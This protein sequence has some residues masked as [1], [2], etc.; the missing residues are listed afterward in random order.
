M[1]T[2]ARI[3]VI[4]D[5][6]IVCESCR[7]VLEQEGYEVSTT[8]EG[9]EGLERAWTEDFDAVIVDIRMPRTSGFEV[10]HG[11]REHKP[12]TAVVMITGYPSV[13]AAVE[14]LRGGATDYLVKPFTPDELCLKVGKAIRAGGDV[15]ARGSRIGE[16]HTTVA[17]RQVATPSAEIL[18]VGA[19]EHADALQEI[20][21]SEQCC[22]EMT[23]HAE[24]VLEKV[25]TGEV[26]VLILGLE[27]F[28][29]HG[30]DL[31]PAVREIKDDIPIIVVSSAQSEELAQNVRRL[32]ILFYLVEPFGAEEV[33][34]VIR[35][36][37]KKVPV[38]KK[39]I[40][41]I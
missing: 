24:E 9:R 34:A 3:L 6:R 32:G 21:R 26:E 16:Q 40:P 25:R 4:D 2:S 23:Y 15:V 7:R 38:F 19:W 31:V 11:I 13:G 29:L 1:K 30:D 12:E 37:A 8:T 27:A 18:I 41:G 5:Q 39:A 28:R 10:L 36:A 33:K 14:T 20:A 17:K 22:V 35:G